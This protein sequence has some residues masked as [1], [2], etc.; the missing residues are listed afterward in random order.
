MGRIGGEWLQHFSGYELGSG[1]WHPSRCGPYQGSIRVTGHS[2]KVSS[3]SI[4]SHTQIFSK[5]ETRGGHF[6]RLQHFSG[7][8][9]GSGTWYPSR[10]GL[11]QG[12]I[13]VTGHSEEVSSRSIFSHTQIFSKC[14][15]RGGLLGRLQHF[16]G[17]ELG[18]GT[19][20]PSH[21]GPYQGS[22]RVTGHSE[23]VSSW[24]ALSHFTARLNIP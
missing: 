10:C 2:E 5:C 16:S 8:E 21:C 7:Y 19:W 12:S 13:R 20:H 22:I 23:E 1:T 24:C 11:Y 4:F 9:L 15:T 3:R 6:G 17:Y 14:E 18:S